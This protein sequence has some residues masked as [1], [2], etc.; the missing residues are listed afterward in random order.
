MAWEE[1]LRELSEEI[2]GPLFTRPEPRATFAD[3]VRGLLADV[4]RK[5]SWQLADHVGHGTA[6]RIEWLLNGAKWDAADADYGRDPDLRE[7]CH[8]REVAYALAVP[9][10]LPLV[11]VRGQAECAGHVLDRRWPR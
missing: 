7:F 10:D 2:A 11:E 5:N 1:D 8:R 3:L 9:V 4:A 6:Y